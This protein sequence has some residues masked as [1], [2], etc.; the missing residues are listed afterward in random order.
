MCLSPIIYLFNKVRITWEFDSNFYDIT[1][2]TMNGGYTITLFCIP[3]VIFTALSVILYQKRHLECA[4]DIVSYFWMKPIFRWLAAFC[5]GTGIAMI[6]TQLFFVDSRYTA[7]VLTLGTILFSCISFFLAEMLLQKKFKVFRKQHWIE[8]CICICATL[9]IFGAVNG[10]IFLLERKVPAT[11]DISAAFIDCDYNY[12]IVL[13]DPDGIEELKDIH[14]TIIDNKKAYEDYYYDHMLIGGESRLPIDTLSDAAPETEQKEVETVTEGTTFAYIR[15]QYYLKNGRSVTRGY[16]IP[17]TKQYLDTAD[18]AAGKIRKMQRSSDAY[19]KYMICDNY[20]DV[21][22]DTGT[23]SYMEGDEYE[24]RDLTADEI[25]TLYEALKKDILSGN[26][27][28][29]IGNNN[30]N[31]GNTYYNSINLKGKI[32]GKFISIFD[33]IPS[34]ESTALQESYS[35]T[36]CYPA[37]NTGKGKSITNVSTDFPITDTCEYTIQAL[38][39]LG[40]IKDKS[41]LLYQEDSYTV[42]GEMYE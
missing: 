23:F 17:A 6:F 31:A 19:L 5:V 9:F 33:A 10:D 4:G 26:Y 20:E 2:I 35:Y 14:Q 15:I 28:C 12:G 40:I 11:E 21:T 18:S 42:S 37:S 1:A 13:T 39:D 16:H 25:L 36:Y 29:C 30:M 3:A 7:I 41:E 8:W 24:Y 32:N 22:Y 27:P 38:I 34:T